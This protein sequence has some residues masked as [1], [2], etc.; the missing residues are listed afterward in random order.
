MLIGEYRH[1]IDEKRRIALPVKFRRAL[2]KTLVI[3]RG[4]DS[5]LFVFSKAQW[6]VIVEKLSQ[7]SMG[8]ADSRAFGRYF[9]AGA[10]ELEV[11]QL[12]RILV[13]SELADHAKLVGDTVLIGVNDRCEMWNEKAWDS[14]RASVEKEADRVAE[15]LGEIGVI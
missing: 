9:F 12:G 10:T 4:L 11:D 8:Q 6:Q 14:Y 13:P 7:L 1:K 5:C 2:G 3:T 15:K